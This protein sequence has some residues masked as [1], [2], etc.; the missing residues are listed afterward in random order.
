MRSVMGLLGAAW[1]LGAAILIGDGRS[2]TMGDPP[3]ETAFGDP[4]VM[5]VYF[6]A[7]ILFVGL[8]ILSLAMVDPAGV[9]AFFRS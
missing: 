7:R 9:K 8:A 5:G 4:T 6:V 3:A 2:G 1:F